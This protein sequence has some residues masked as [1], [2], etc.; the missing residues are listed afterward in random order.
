[1]YYTKQTI[2]SLAVANRNN[3][4]ISKILSEHV[5]M[6]RFRDAQFCEYSALMQKA[7]NI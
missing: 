5:C 4:S 2:Q 1:M 6:R 3:S 7:K